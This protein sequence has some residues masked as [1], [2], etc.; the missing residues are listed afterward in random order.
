MA[1]EQVLSTQGICLAI[2][3][4]STALQT[5][6]R[7][8]DLLNVYPVPDGDTGTNMALTLSAVC[9]ALDGLPADQK[10]DR[11]QVCETISQ[12]ALMGARGNSGVIISQFLRAMV[13]VLAAA[14]ERIGAGHLADGLKDGSASADKSVME[15]VEGTILSVA[16]AVAAVAG[17]AAA[18]LVAKA[19]PADPETDL[20]SQPSICQ[21]LDEALTAGQVALE[22]TPEQLPVLAQ[23]GVVDAGGVGF[24]LWLNALLAVVDDRPLPEALA[25]PTHVKDNLAKQAAT[26]Q[27][28]SPPSTS[29][30]DSPGAAAGSAARPDLGPRYEVMYLLDSTEELVD[31]FR[32]SWSQLGDSIVVAGGDG[33]WNCHIHTDQ[34]GATIEAGITAGRPHR[35]AI[36]DLHEQVSDLEHGHAHP[37]AHDHPHPHDHAASTTPTSTTP[38]TTSAAVVVSPAPGLDQIFSSIGVATLVSGGQTMNP[39][40]AELLAAIEATASEE[41]ILLPNNA[42]IITT[43]NQAAQHAAKQVHVVP[44]RTIVHGLAAMIGFDPDA[45]AASNA[46]QMAELASDVIA[47]EVT[48]AVRSTTATASA[49]SASAGV[50]KPVN[51]GDWIGIRAEGKSRIIA[52]ADNLAD[53]AIDLLSQL[54]QPDHDALTVIIGEQATEADTQ[55]IQ[56]W[57]TQTHASIEADFLFGE[58]PHYPY[59]FGL[60]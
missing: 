40:T 28:A 27:L 43:A 12:A 17:D 6:R 36:T 7:T 59:L 25:L 18:D 16:R 56:T 4:F 60:E 19:D 46:T 33:L 55:A 45:D 20:A 2:E 44:T 49:G 31:Q 35:I 51:K 14:P 32:Q 41:I 50:A 3:K 11:S 15:P 8:I 13:A 29:A 48:Q 47:A 5:H 21:V 54:I 42:N 58:Q 9:E 38:T 30:A 1:S 34:I 26:G 53:A 52:V 39:S 37:H 24:L 10:S 23:A 57:L 22:F